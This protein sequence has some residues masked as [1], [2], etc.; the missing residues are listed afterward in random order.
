[1]LRVSTLIATVL[2]LTGCAHRA[3]KSNQLPANVHEPELRQIETEDEYESIRTGF[4]ALEIEDGARQ[5]LRRSL[6][7]Y[8][9]RQLEKA[10]RTGHPDD[11]F[12]PFQ[13]MLTLYDPSEI[14]GPVDAPELLKAAERLESVLQR[15]GAHQQ[16]MTALCVE[17]ST[18]RH[19]SAGVTS[20]YRLLVEW[21]KSG[22]PAED[23]DRVHD[24]TARVI[25]DLEAVAKVWP[26]DFVVAQLTTLY[27]PQWPRAQG[28]DARGSKSL[29]RQAHSFSAAFRLT[30]LYLWAS[31]PADGFAMLQKMGSLS[32]EEGQLRG[33][34]GKVASPDSQPSDAIAMASLFTQTDRDDRQIA[35]RICHDAARRFASAIEPQLCA[36]QVAL[37]LEKMVV[38]QKSFEQVIKLEPTRRE[39]WEAL[40][41]IYQARLFQMASDENLDVRGLEPQL[42]TV[43]R[44]HAAAER[45]F[46]SRPLRPSLGNAVFEVGR[47]YYNAGRLNE[48]KRYL[49][50]TLAT[51]PNVPA[52]E[53]LG[54]IAFKKGEAQKAAALFAKAVAVPGDNRAERLF[55]QARIQRQ[56]GDASEA[57]GDLSTADTARRSALDDWDALTEIGLT[58]EGAA[59][60]DLE[61]AKIFYALR[62]RDIA[63]RAIEKA[64]DAAPDRGS[65]YADAIAFLVARGELEEALDAYHRALGRSEVT[66]YLKVYCSLWIVDLAR[67]AGQPEDPLATAFLNSTDGG[68]WYHTLA[69]WATGR[70]TEEALLEK[71]DTPA[72]RAEAS[73]YRAMRAFSEGRSEDA[74][75]LWREVLSSDMLAFF[76]Y[77]MASLYLKWGSAPKEP[78]LKSPSS[79]SEFGIDPRTFKRLLE[80][81]PQ[82]KI[83]PHGKV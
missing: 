83:L 27:E 71:A 45:R 76:E 39:A 35:L 82:I 9:S 20:R 68:K 41:Q 24:G 7:S 44:F 32:E 14:R 2:V 70:E 28:T 79:H 36:G 1:M 74:Q 21:L 81:R 30:R 38:A 37:S 4:D 33:L 72:R 60:A 62:N 49:E 54:Q 69:R 51:D 65:T 31:R 53:L 58:P 42:T 50:E 67:R 55:V 17:H 29:E 73:F 47:G 8:L 6:E 80:K 43:Q 46:P 19:E 12:E 57:A 56:L 3:M 59:E 78:I 75:A 10:L 23:D 16:V 66:E 5:R 52:L 64:I 26:S 18:S 34:L 63:L 22:G 15:R 40:A 48:A 61:R 13:Q 77:E 25:S 11:A